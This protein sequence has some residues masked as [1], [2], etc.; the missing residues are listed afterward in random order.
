MKYS[1]SNWPC[2]LIFAYK[3]PMTKDDEFNENLDTILKMYN[4][5]ESLFVIEDLNMD[6]MSIKGDK[7]TSLCY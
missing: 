6:W 7:L 3:P 1:H 4:P 2:N 5:T